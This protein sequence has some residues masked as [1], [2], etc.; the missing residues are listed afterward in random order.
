[1]KLMFPNEY[2]VYLHDTPEQDLF[3]QQPAG[4]QFR[5]RSG[6]Q[7]CRTRRVGAA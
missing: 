7:A 6:E 5:L 4:F 1:M 2:S 3:E